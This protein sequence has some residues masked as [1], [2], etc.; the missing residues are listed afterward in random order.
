M[1]ARRARQQREAFQRFDLMFQEWLE[2]VQQAVADDLA[3]RGAV[4]ELQLDYVPKI[5]LDF[6]G[7]CIRTQRVGQRLKARELCRDIGV[8]EATL[9]RIERGDPMVA[10]ISYLMAMAR[11]GIL[12]QLIPEPPEDL[13]QVESFWAH[14]RTPSGRYRA[15]PDERLRRVR[16][17]RR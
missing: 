14:Y 12:G 9:R 10:V 2:P 16:D 1:R 15:P 7:R 8:S 3:R 17:S 13:W 11:L 4:P 5:R 6:W